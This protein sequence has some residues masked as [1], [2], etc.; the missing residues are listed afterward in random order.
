METSDKRI[1]TLIFLFFLTLFT[2]TAGNDTINPRG[3]ASIMHEM[4]KNFV[5]FHAFSLEPDPFI[6]DNFEEL[7]ECFLKNS[8]G[9][10]YS[11][12][13]IAQ[14]IIEVPFIFLQKIY[15]TLAIPPCNSDAIAD[16]IIIICPALISALTS[17]F[18][19]LF[20]R[21]FDLDKKISIFAA[22]CFGL[23]TFV[24]PHAKTLMSEP[25]QNLF[26]LVTI[27]NSYLFRKNHKPV[28]LIYAGLCFGMLVLAKN[29][30]IL[31]MLLILPYLICGN[32]LLLKKIK[33]IVVYFFLP[34]SLFIIIILYYNYLRTNNLFDFAYA[35]GRDKLFGFNTPIMTGL[36]GLLCSSGKGFFWYSPIL[37]VAL[38]GFKSFY[39][40]RRQE[41][42][43]FS[44]IIISTLLMYAK[45][46][47]WHGDWSWGPRFMLITV[48]Y[49]SIPLAYIFE[50]IKA[51]KI[52]VAFVIILFLFSFFIQVIGVTIPTFHFFTNTW[53][54]FNTANIAAFAPSQPKEYL[55]DDMALAHF[56][57]E[58][59]P[60]LYHFWLFKHMITFDYA[61]FDKDYPWKSLNISFLIPK[62]YKTFIPRFDIWLLSRDFSAKTMIISSM[63]L[64]INFL[65]LI[66][67]V[68]YLRGK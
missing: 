32:R 21:E 35:G 24:W 2:L 66:E 49:F 4:A 65:S 43:L 60:I 30:N 31:F 58:F 28:Y 12:Y 6:R 62:D 68:R 47:A 40:R 55:R 53:K 5:Y 64:L 9:R 51:K 16:L 17:I 25:A 1:I 39:I 19:Y 42:I 56:V 20:C 22:L 34:F 38:F 7:K 10:I 33:E 67:I 48:P 37:I 57:P 63:L 61:S 13:G 26:L 54:V 11:K 41:C 44:A 15:L 3:D 18:I 45:W 29:I 14:S 27:F 23:G 52:L 50:R 59:S 8:R 36:Y 46:W